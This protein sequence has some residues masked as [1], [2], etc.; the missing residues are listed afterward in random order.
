MEIF[1]KQPRELCLYLGLMLALSFFRQKAWTR[2]LYLVLN[3][4]GVY[5]LFF[6][7]LES[8]KGLGVF[9]GYLAYAG[10]ILSIGLFLLKRG[11]LYTAAL[12][13]I[14]GWI[15]IQLA[16]LLT[17]ADIAVWLGSGIVPI[18]GSI[19]LLKAKS[20]WLGFSYLTFRLSLLMTEYQRSPSFWGAFAYTFDPKTL[21]VGPINSYYQYQEFLRGET[22]RTARTFWLSLMRIAVGLF[23]FY[24]ISGIFYQLTLTRS[25]TSGQALGFAQFLIG[26]VTY[27][28]Y[29]Y[30][31]FS[32]FCDVIVGLSA[33]SG[34]EVK[35]NFNQ[36]LL[37]TNIR[38]FWQ[39]WHISLTDYLNLMIFNPISKWILRSRFAKTYNWQVPWISTLVLTIMGLWH[40]LQWN[41]MIFAW[42]HSLGLILHH[43]Y[44]TASF[45]K[46]SGKIWCGI[47]WAL[48]FTWISIAFF[49][50]ENSLE[51]IQEICTAL[52]GVSG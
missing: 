23:K 1:F 49:F 44:R 34:L 50:F 12:V 35:E 39:R 48:T 47:A 31:N 19:G 37:A 33:L 41:Y 11:W 38:S 51:R 4:W 7:S 26:I 42:F 43:I 28:V 13:P 32:G 30:M 3:L 21:L 45:R 22:F 25:Y 46:P 36:P 27:T 9:L 52:S 40:G 18:V 15:L 14:I 24:L 6:S 17:F 20:L 16:G 10:V 2:F 29:I 8:P 5:I